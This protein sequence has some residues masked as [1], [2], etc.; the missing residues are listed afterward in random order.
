MRLLIITQK[1]DINDDILGFFHRWLE[2]FAQRFKKITV[3]CLQKGEYSLPANVKVLSLGK[4]KYLHH[5]YIIRRLVLLLR[6]YKSIW[7]ERKNYDSVFV[8]MNQEYILLSGLFWSILRKKIY[9]WRNHHAGNILTD[10]AGFF[11]QKVFCTSKYSYTAKYKKTILMPVGIDTNFFKKGNSSK[12]KNNSILFLAR[13]SPVKKPHLV[14]EALRQIRDKEISFTADFFGN[15]LAKDIPYLESIKE[16]IKD[17]R[18]YDL[19]NFKKGV[20]YRETPHIYNNHEIFV[21]PSPSG[22]YDKTIFEAMACE[23]LVLTSNLNLRGEIDDVFIFKEDDEKDLAE[24]IEHLFSWSAET[25]E[26][27]GKILRVYVVEHHSLEK[28]VRELAGV[29][30]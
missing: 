29:L 5:S 18:L 24:K 13:M 4:E 6:F 26:N 10:V 8:H 20:P 7:Q 2:K 25:K 11:C 3:I 21:N 22:M 19:V 16:K 28:L 23:S 27:Y 15:P 14:I 30:A 17:Y 9:M 12:R 1:V